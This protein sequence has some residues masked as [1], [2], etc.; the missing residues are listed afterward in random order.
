MEDKIEGRL[1]YT[2]S[3]DK[4]FDSEGEEYSVAMLCRK[5][6]YS[7]IE[8]NTTYCGVPYKNCLYVSDTDDINGKYQCM[9][10]EKQA[11]GIR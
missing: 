9:C 3:I 4:L 8:G 1:Q 5:Y 6:N 2:D 7:I 11:G 10:L